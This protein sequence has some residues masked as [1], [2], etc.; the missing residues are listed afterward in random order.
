[1]DEK[2]TRNEGGD[3]NEEETK[4][5]SEISF[6][7]VMEHL[8]EEYQHMNSITQ[9]AVGSAEAV[10]SHVHEQS[11]SSGGDPNLQ[12]ELDRALQQF[13][14]NLATLHTD[15]VTRMIQVGFDV[16]DDDSIHN[17]LEMAKAGRE[18]SQR[19]AMLAGYEAG[20]DTRI[21]RS[22]SKDVYLLPDGRVLKIQDIQSFLGDVA[23]D[24]SEVQF[25]NRIRQ[26][27]GSDHARRLVADTEYAAPGVPAYIQERVF[28]TSRAMKAAV[29]AGD[30]ELA[31]LF[32]EAHRANPLCAYFLFEQKD[33]NTGL[34]LRDGKLYVVAFDTAAG[35]GE[36]DDLNYL[37]DQLQKQN[38]SR[39]PWEVIR[40]AA[41]NVI[42][43][44]PK[45]VAHI[46]AIR[47]WLDTIKQ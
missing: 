10:V 17:I 25:A 3:A 36:E 42:A 13:R 1:M 22:N 24:G 9:E 20:E 18:G 31:S 15:Y 16:T 34:V 21:A 8:G 40:E 39:D 47:Q 45:R 5:E 4:P 37:K 2:L 44:D 12:E 30:N 29:E 43:I 46:P 7:K 27:L 6:G 38:D 41:Q 23:V 35:E 28:Q 14:E 11:A 33:R 32:K 26:H 19:V